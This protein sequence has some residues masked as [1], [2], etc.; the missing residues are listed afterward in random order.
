MIEMQTFVSHLFMWHSMTRRF[1]GSVRF[2]ESCPERTDP[3][4]LHNQGSSMAYIHS[5]H[6]CSQCVV[7]VCR[8]AQSPLGPVTRLHSGPRSTTLPGLWRS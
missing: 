2:S 1:G 8:Q 6:Q 3:I 7:L 4:H 5:V